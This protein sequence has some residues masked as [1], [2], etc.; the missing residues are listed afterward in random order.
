MFFDVIMPLP[1]REEIKQMIV[2]R[3]A[4]ATVAT[5]A[6]L[7]P[8]VATVAGGTFFKNAF[9]DDYGKSVLRAVGSFGGFYMGCLAT[10]P[11][12]AIAVALAILKK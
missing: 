2:P 12:A 6:I 3:S 9:S 4:A 11:V 10:L 7:I 5:V 8:I 1:S